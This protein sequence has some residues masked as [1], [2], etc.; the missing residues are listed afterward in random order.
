LVTSPCSNQFVNLCIDIWGLFLS[1][2]KGEAGETGEALL[3][4]VLIEAGDSLL[5]EAGKAL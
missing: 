4:E 5:I 3:I 2:K 1:P